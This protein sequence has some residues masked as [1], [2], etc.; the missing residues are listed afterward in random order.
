[1]NKNDLIDKLWQEFPEFKRK[2]L[3][4]IVNLLFERL[5]QALKE[6]ERIEIR[7]FGRFVVK[8]QKERFFKNPK[9]G[10]EQIIPARKRIIFKVGKD[11]KERLNQPAFASLDLGTQTFRLL[12]GKQ[13]NPHF[14]AICKERFNVR[15]G[16]ELAKEGLISE[17]AF[18]RGLKALKQIR[19]RLD[20]INVKNVFAAGTEVFRRAKNA[21]KFLEKAEKI[22][23]FPIKVLTPQEEAIYTA[24]GVLFSL[25]IKDY[26]ALI[27]DVG[28]GS[29]EYILCDDYQILKTGS[30]KLGAV[31]LKDRF[32]S[33][34][35]IPTPL[36]IGR[37]TQEILTILSEIK[38]LSPKPATLIATGGTATCLA[39]LSQGLE[40][41]APSKIHG[42]SL[43]V[44]ALKN[45][46]KKLASLSPSDRK[47]LK[48]ME[49]G[50]EDIILSGALIYQALL[51]LLEAKRILI[52]DTGILEGIL[53]H[54]LEKSPIIS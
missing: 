30:L 6:E 12:V 13:A 14:R 21:D 24:K 23:G 5:T 33:S 51:D 53:L 25:K 7:G 1:M 18:E 3:E 47:Y 4:F 44:N 31:L 20:K 42:Y 11:L 9:T 48:G 37:A 35:D 16:E 27:V 26:P 15:L 34:D 54:L 29:T 40:R 50:R 41:Y 45:L 52:S 19:Q 10:E 22:L 39:A 17:Q 28:G 2:D 46:V 38:N 36:E 43:K 49:E 32:F 8:K